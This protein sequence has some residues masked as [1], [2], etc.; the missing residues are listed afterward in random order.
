MKGC[1][2]LAS[3][4]G[5]N[6]E[7]DWS[8]SGLMFAYYLSGAY[9]FAFASFNYAAK[10]EPKYTE[11]ASKSLNM[12]VKNS[13]GIMLRWENS[14]WLNFPSSIITTFKTSLIGNYPLSHLFFR[15]GYGMYRQISR[16]RYSENLDDK[17][18]RYL[19]KFLGI[20]TSTIDPFSNYPDMFMTSEVLDCLSYS[21]SLEKKNDLQ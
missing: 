14:E 20:E 6:G 11:N 13:D 17:A 21:L 4:Q 18:F 2:W 19:T 5:K 7:F 12:L 9:G 10:W 8:K 16:R 1:N 3:V 15:F